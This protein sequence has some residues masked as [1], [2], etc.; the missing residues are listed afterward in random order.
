MKILK[1][2]A[3]L[4]I[5]SFQITACTRTTNPEPDH[6]DEIE[7]LNLLNVYSIEGYQLELYGENPK[8]HVGYNKVYFLLTDDNGKNVD[9]VSINWQPIMHMEMGGMTHQHSCPYSDISK[10]EG[11]SNLYEAYVVFIMPG[12]GEHNFWNLEINIHLIDRQLDVEAGVDVQ[13]TESDFYKV[14]T[15]GMG[16]DSSIYFLAL[17]EPAEPKIGKNDMLVALFKKLDDFNFPMVDDY[18]ILVDPRMPGMGNHSAPGNEDLI[19]KEDGFYHG[20]VGFSMTGY[21][22]INLIL[23]NAIGQRIKGEPVSETNLESSLH[24]KLEF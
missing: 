9:P 6:S 23:E 11:K 12:D 3:V 18:K 1:Y 16:I 17:I 7:N 13:N 2:Y 15:S 14:F 21:W 8:L 10:V 5:M 19:Q 24:F 4:L 22:K 20:K